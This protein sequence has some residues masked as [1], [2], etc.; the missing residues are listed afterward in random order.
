MLDSFSPRARQIVF[1]ARFKAGERG[2]TKIETDDFLV[3]LLLEDQGMLERTVF[4]KLEGEGTLVNQAPSHTPFF[5]SVLAQDL[6]VKLEKSLPQSQ[7]VAPT[8]EM[9]LSASLERVFKVA[10]GL[11]VRLKQ[12]QIEPLH[13]LAAAM[14]EKSDQ[15]VKLLQDSG[16]APEK[17]LLAISKGLASSKRTSGP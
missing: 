14:E 9:P 10:E 6:L 11:Q 1:A 15:G 5:S 12:N 8:T 17:V 2:A 4:R 16:I 3:S 7:P 13:L